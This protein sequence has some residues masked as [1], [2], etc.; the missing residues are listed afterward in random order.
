MAGTLADVDMAIARLR[1]AV[2]AKLA[3]RSVAIDSLLRPPPQT[4]A[5]I[6][7]PV[8]VTPREPHHQPDVQVKD[9]Q[10]R[11]TAMEMPRPEI[12]TPIKPSLLSRFLGIFRERS[13]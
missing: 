5:P 4:P 12:S 2:E 9:L 6:R 10:V 1:A 3:S 13:R 8:P 11:K 7:I